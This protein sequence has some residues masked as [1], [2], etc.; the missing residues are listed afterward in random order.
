MIA[1]ITLDRP[2]ARNA[3]NDVMSAELPRAFEALAKDYRGKI[4][5]AKLD[6]DESPKTA[7]SLSIHSIPT[8]LFYKDGNQLFCRVITFA[9][10]TTVGLETSLI[11]SANLAARPYDACI[12]S[13][14][15]MVAYGWT[16][17][18]TITGTNS[19][20]ASSSARSS[21]PPARTA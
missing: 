17:G 5:F 21:A 7:M 16:D 10:P 15:P 1:V 8:L 18:V 3:M 2:E 11:N 12:F 20:L 13:G 4:S 14:L 19:A 9:A 6:T